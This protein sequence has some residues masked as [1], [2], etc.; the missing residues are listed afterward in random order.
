[1]QSKNNLRIQPALAWW[2]FKPGP[3]H[4]RQVTGIH[5]YAKER[6]VLSCSI[7]A[8]FNRE[9]GT[10]LRPTSPLL[11]TYVMLPASRRGTSLTNGSNRSLRSLGPA[12]AGP[13]T[14][15]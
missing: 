3:H 15:R 7:A 13:L 2:P 8:G 14:K 9:P 4:L 11:S 1:M 5:A 12:K 10:R 6:P